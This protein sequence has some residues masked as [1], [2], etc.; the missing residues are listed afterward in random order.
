MAG[1]EP[2]ERSVTG[3]IV[4]GRVEPVV[5]LGPAARAARG[6][7]TTGAHA[8]PAECAP[9]E[10]RPSVGRECSEWAGTTRAHAARA[11]TQGRNARIATAM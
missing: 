10:R 2:F 6:E 11:D 4:M 7:G 8:R 9:R 1:D 5:Q 3:E